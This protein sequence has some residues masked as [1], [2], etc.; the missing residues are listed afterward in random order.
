MAN[1]P[2]NEAH[3]SDPVAFK[4]LLTTHNIDFLDFG[5]SIG[6]SIE[7]GKRRLGG[8]C[9]L[10]IDIDENKVAR[11]K[12]AGFQ[13]LQY[14]IMDIPDERLVRF[15]VMSHFLEH[16][17][18]LVDVKRFIRKACNI[19]TDFVYIQQ[20]FFDADSYLFN[21]GLKLFWSDWTGHRNRMSS[22]EMWLT[23]RDLAREGLPIKFSLHANK[24]IEDSRHESIHPIDSPPNQHAY[25]ETLHPPK[26][27][28]EFD[29]NVFGELICL[30]TMPN[31]DHSKMLQ[32]LRYNR[33]IMPAD[34][35][36]IYQSI[37]TTV[38]DATGTQLPDN[39]SKT[40]VYSTNA[41]LSAMQRLKIS[42]ERGYRYVIN[43]GKS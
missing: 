14:E 40:T 4:N 17:P 6:G 7:F 10:G 28:M 41:R 8:Q 35:R 36:T 32:A 5:C 29:D 31:C 18:S 20:P 33:T 25:S 23:L 38:A 15:V 30:I 26:R 22:L 43:G 16:I 27:N 3:Y 21:R 19:S 24:P 1:R 11:S 12:D 42:L 34:W 37:N 39:K 13:A 2:N 9:G